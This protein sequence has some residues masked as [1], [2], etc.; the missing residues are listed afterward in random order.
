MNS[1][2]RKVL[3][4][5]V[6]G[7]TF[8][9]IKP[10]IRKGRLPN[11]EKMIEKGVHGVLNSTIPIVSPVAWTSFMTGKNPEKHQIFDFF[12]KIQGSYKF[13]INTA[14]DRK[15][16]PIWMNISERNKKVMVIGVTMTYP[17]DPVN[18]YM[19]SG[20][21]APLDSHMERYTFPPDFAKEIV[22]NFGRFKTSPGVN[23]RKIN[24]SDKEKE[25]Y[26]KGIF[27]LVDYRV[28]L[29]KHMWVKE[30]FN[31]SMIFFL[32]T[33]GISHCFW[34][35]IDSTHKHFQPGVYGDTIYK[36]YENVDSAIGKLLAIIDDGVDVVLV[37]DHGFGPLNKVVFLNNWLESKGYLEFK[38]TS[39]FKEVCS[40]IIT[41]VKRKKRMIKGGIDWQKTE[42]Y[43]HG[44]VGNIFINLRGREP[45][46]IVDIKE[47][48]DLC[49]DLKVGLLNIEDPETGEKVVERVYKKEELY[50]TKDIV[51][52]PD[53]VVTFKKGYSVIGADIHFH[54]LKDTGEIITNSKNW[55]GT[56]EREGVF[57]AYGKSFKK[58]HR[59]QSANIIDVAPTILYLLGM[60]IPESYDGKILKNIF[61][62]EIQSN[63][64]SYFK[65]EDIF[66]GESEGYT[67]GENESVLREL[68]NL[69]YI[70]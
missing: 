3:V 8:K 13:K 57:I 1:P 5:G 9:I 12:G 46:G 23:L 60:P 37:S 15:A 25:K 66:N 43:F 53:L 63:P 30:E 6:D 21:G 19:V 59:C 32:D 35:D 2:N 41:L 44:T 39:W 4:I 26:L 31:F 10:L 69:G 51:I 64:V 29:F 14:N 61:T 42:A 68:R 24:S 45:D 49:D 11:L 50:K 52:A 58:G 56:H 7:A 47:Y 54:D 48:D 65:D 67:E 36:I 33:D 55:S 18:G 22:G 20:Q 34:K 40:Y 62:D 70:D 17:P 16:K 27:E 28:N 38:H